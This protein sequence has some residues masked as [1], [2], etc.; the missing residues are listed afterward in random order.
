M[1][2]L[3]RIADL[4]QNNPTITWARIK[5]ILERETSLRWSSPEALR[6]WWRRQRHNYRHD[7]DLEPRDVP[8][9]RTYV[10]AAHETAQNRPVQ[11]GDTST[12][13]A[14]IPQPLP[15]PFHE[16]M[17][18]PM[19]R[20]LVIADIHAPFHDKQFLDA[21]LYLHGAE[22]DAIIIAGDLFDFAQ[23]SRHP[24]DWNVPR[25]ETEM[26]LAG[27]VLLALAQIAPLYLCN[28]NHDERMAVKL[29]AALTLQRL[30]YASLGGETPKNT[31][32]V[33]EYDYIDVGNT[34]TVGHLSQFHKRPGALAATIADMHQRHV[35]V[36][37][38]HLLGAQLSKSGKWVGASIGC[39]AQ[40]DLFW[41][42]ER[43]LNTYAPM[44]QGYAIIR[45][46][47]EVDIYNNAH[48]P[49]FRR[50]RVADKYY[51][52]WLA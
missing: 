38:D 21:L 17:R 52:S 26:A 43:R 4:K 49:I 22:V 51:N 20:A 8:P 40:P 13:F 3:Q 28:G 48:V 36:G 50:Y 37:H 46:E 19:M 18:L 15:K 30:I 41:Y 27:K 24:R 47:H 33:T 2:I 23:I 11:N 16:P 5:D 14:R 42:S 45:A 44:A 31:I 35:L 6:S 34:F 32:T 29:N 12:S 39:I 25:L 7:D 10:A 9:S 1:T